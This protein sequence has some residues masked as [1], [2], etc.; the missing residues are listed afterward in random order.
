MTACLS[1][2]KT[3]TLGSSLTIAAIVLIRLLLRKVLSPKAKYYLWLLLAL[4]LC[5]VAVPESSL[6]LMNFLPQQA[7]P[8][9]AASQELELVPEMEQPA[10]EAISEPIQN[11][12][13]YTQTQTTSE[14]ISKSAR[15]SRET[16]LFWLW[17]T[18]MGAV[19]LVDGCLYVL[20]ALRLSR[21]PQ[22]QDSETLAC[23]SSLKG[24]LRFP[25]QVRLVRGSGGMSGGLLHSTIVLP[26]ECRGEAA[27]PV[28]L[29]ELQHIRAGDLWL[30]AFYRLLRAIY[31]FDPLLWLCF[32]QIRLD[33]EAACDQRVLESGLVDK[34]SYAETLYQEGKLERSGLYYKTAFGGGQHALRDRIRQISRYGG[35]KLWML[36][37]GLALALAVTACTMTAARSGTA[38]AEDTGLET[39]ASDSSTFTVQNS[40]D[41]VA[42]D[43]EAQQ[44]DSS[45]EAQSTEAVFSPYVM[46]DGVLTYE[47]TQWGMTREQ[48]AE[49][50][51]LSEDQYT[52]SNKGQ[53]FYLTLEEPFPEHPAVYEVQFEFH[54]QDLSMDPKLDAV[55]LRYDSELLSYDRILQQR[56][57]GLGSPEEQKNNSASWTE[58]S[59][60]WVDLSD[61]S[62]Y[63]KERFGLEYSSTE[64]D[65][66]ADFDIEDFMAS[67]QPP[68]GHYG[69]TYE[70][71]VA[72]G[73]L[74]PSSGEYSVLESGEERFETTI[75]LGGETVNA[76]Y[77][78]T[79]SVLTVGSEKRVLREV[80][81]SLPEN[82][83]LS[84]WVDSFSDSFLD[85]MYARDTLNYATSLRVA[86]FLTE[87]QQEAISAA[88]LEVTGSGGS[89]QSWPLATNW[90]DSDNRLWKFNGTGYALYLDAMELLEP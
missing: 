28:L 86:N 65:I 5:L 76:I 38:Q 11:T 10:A 34:A 43:V 24:Q 51:E 63:V 48:V 75:T 61:G 89:T 16:I 2:L 22:C 18:G 72:A 21:L 62:V 46:L 9:E 60:I 36:P 15:P 58:K 85:K 59:G 32:R 66:L 57:E 52:L 14:P 70:E 54:Y 17:L 68:N 7:E 56:A 12:A 29:H 13:Q 8:V 3:I 1:L 37:L 31:W 74:D 41:D 47:D 35:K 45:G 6:S 69:W 82:V 80:H 83:V 88:I 25:H 4:R 42:A 26:T 81:I 73:L 77:W 87:N 78:F 33:C 53:N 79:P 44:P 20:T 64:E 67:L 50:L 27:T 84:Q 40:E 71:H 23:F 19:L 55:Q 49:A 30:L 90:Y 39:E